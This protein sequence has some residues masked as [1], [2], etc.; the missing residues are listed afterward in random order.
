MQDIKLPVAEESLEKM[1]S[2]MKRTLFFFYL[3]FSTATFSDVVD[4]IGM[5]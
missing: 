5:K 2:F 4:I 1:K 3:N